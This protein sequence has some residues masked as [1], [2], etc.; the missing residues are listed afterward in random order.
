MGPSGI[1][2]GMFRI[3]HVP[4]KKQG[5]DFIVYVGP[6]CIRLTHPKNGGRFSNGSKWRSPIGRW[7][8]QC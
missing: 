7:E 4:P 2:R 6:W 3:F 8:N 5:F 1:L